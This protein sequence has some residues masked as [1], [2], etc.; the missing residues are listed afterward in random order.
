MPSMPLPTGAAQ[1]PRATCKIPDIYCTFLALCLETGEK[2]QVQAGLD[3]AIKKQEAWQLRVG[4]YFLCKK[5][6]TEQVDY[7]F[8]V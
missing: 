8:V 7:R 4:F 1:K 2:Q 3:F 5:Q 6:K